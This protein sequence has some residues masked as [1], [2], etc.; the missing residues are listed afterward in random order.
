M[1][2]LPPRVLPV[3]QI[4]FSGHRNL[5]QADAALLQA[6]LGAV[7]A[8]IDAAAR[9]A[10]AQ[11]WPGLTAAEA[12]SRLEL[13][14]L[15]ALAAG[16]D[17]FMARAV[18]AAGWPLV[19][20]LPFAR[21]TYRGD[22]ETDAEKTEY[23]ALLAKAATVHELDGIAGRT[24]SYRA[25]GRVVLEQSDILVA[26][27][28][29]NLERG[30]GGTAEVVREARATD[31]PVI[32]VDPA[33]PHA[34]RVLASGGVGIAAIVAGLLAPPR[35]SGVDA[36]GIYYKEGRRDAP[37]LARR[38]ARIE[39][40]LLAFRPAQPPPQAQTP[41][42]VADADAADVPFALAQAALLPALEAADQLA[43]RYATLY[44]ASISLKWLAV[45]PSA[46]AALVLL[47]VRAPWAAPLSLVA[48]LVSGVTF[49]IG[50]NDRHNGWHRRFLD[51][52]FMA[53]HLR[54]APLMAMFGSTST[55][56]RLPPYQASA[57]SDW[58]NWY[59]RFCLRKL[60]L[61][62]A[63]RGGAFIA[64]MRQKVA[65]EIAGQ[66]AF[67]AARTADAQLVARRLQFA[68]MIAYFAAWGLGMLGAALKFA[69]VPDVGAALSGVGSGH[70]MLTRLLALFFLL[71]ASSSVFGMLWPALSGFRAQREYFRLSQRYDAMIRQLT[72]LEARLARDGGAPGQVERVAREAVEAMLAEVS[73][74]RVLIKA[75]DFSAY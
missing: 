74:W 66:A 6:K 38:L 73:D 72:Q 16:A 65:E 12:L 59:L 4:G 33:A 8:E 14:G 11:G 75:R 10:L 29:G 25:V 27:W 61:V 60:G 20:P 71:A 18:L 63:R 21:E 3:L 35:Q 7:L 22:F 46:F 9:A 31:I 24:D 41:E 62:P 1:S 34:V 55:L 36:I 30:P 51:Y 13:R 15:S 49:L 43:I 28:D 68:T 2:P 64:R 48:L 32:V 54:Y 42:P 40:P 58:V 47:Y 70:D 39:R 37:G 26:V 44:R 67:Y 23:D 17:R 52:R 56:P 5:P 53:E 50:F 19:A 45:F 69:G 57:N